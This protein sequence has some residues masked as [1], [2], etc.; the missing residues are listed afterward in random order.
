MAHPE[1]EVLGPRRRTVDPEPV[2]VDPDAVFMAALEAGADD[3]EISDEAVEVYT[4]RTNFAQ[5]SQALEAAGIRPDQAELMMQ[6]NSTLEL[7]ADE[8]QAVLGLIDALE[9]LDDV[10]K[11]YHNL[12]LTEEM[13][14][15]FA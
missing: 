7:G 6:P 11:V 9:E 5:L 15:L 3:V 8:A 4:D 2:A 10:N 12:E 14:A 13:V 1:A